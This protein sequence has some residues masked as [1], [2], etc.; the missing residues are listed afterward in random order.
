M[1]TVLLLAVSLL[2]A[3][4]AAAQSGTTELQARLDAPVSQYSL[5]GN[6]IADALAKIAKQFELPMGIEWV[7]DKEA[8]RSF[9]RTWSNETVRHVLR[10]IVDAYPGYAFRVDRGVVHVF[11]RDLANDSHNFLNLK[12]PE[13]FEVRQEVGG[14]ANVQLREVV[15]NIVS[16]RNLPPGAGVGGSY[17]TGID[18]KPLTLTLR[19]LTV[20]EA[21]DKLV[22]ASEHKIWIVTFSDAPGRTPTGF[23]RTETLWHPTPFPD[24]DQPMWDFLTWQEYML[25]SAPVAQPSKP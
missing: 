2:T 6:G 10:S 18:E 7:K 20:R 24:K 5:S 1:R 16:P 4:N 21:L 9:S 13:F 19:G 15:Q 11:R 12:V 22:D 14:F 8:L 23:R 3:A 25:I 17:A